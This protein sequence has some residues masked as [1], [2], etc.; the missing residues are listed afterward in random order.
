MGKTPHKLENG[1]TVIFDSDNHKYILNN[2][3]DDPV[4]GMSSILKYLAAP[5]LEDWKRNEL[6]TAISTQ[7]EKNNIPLDKISKIISEAKASMN[8]KSDNILNTGKVVHKLAEKWLKGD[9]ITKPDD[10]V[11]ANCFM[12]F[13]KFWKKHKLKLVES[14]KILYSLRGYCGTLDII[15]IDPDGNI[16]LIDIKTSSGLFLNHVHQLHGYKLAYEEQTGKKINKMYMV[17]LPKTGEGFEARQILY[18]KEHIKAFLGLL[19]CHN[20]TKLFKEQMKKLKDKQKKA[21][22]NGGK[23]VR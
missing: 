22:Y 6:V 7:M 12:E 8:K 1:H 14:E 20:S 13:Q 5:K 2:N 3:Y 19:H 21:K 15:A 10:F 17:R 23:N 18:K 11:I 4:I 16:W 9:K